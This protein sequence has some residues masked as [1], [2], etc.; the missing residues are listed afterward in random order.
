[1]ITTQTINTTDSLV[2]FQVKKFGL[3]KVNGTI[4]GLQGQINFDPQNLEAA[5]FDVSVELASIN[6]AS[7]KRDEH[8]KQSDF[9]DVANHPHIS[10]K[11]SRVM[12]VGSGYK[13]IGTLTIRGI[14]KEVV[15]PFE[16]KNNRF[17]GNL[18]IHR[19]DFQVGKLPG[20]IVSKKIAVSITCV[21]G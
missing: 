16:Y 13:A 11:S 19:A 12:A 3:M 10:F 20:F 2:N 8:L 7:A 17:E 5:N 4:S 15:I 18:E 9:F 6:T 21:M 1:M 14:A